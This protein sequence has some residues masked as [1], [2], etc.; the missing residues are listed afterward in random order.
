MTPTLQC[1]MRYAVRITLLALTFGLLNL[2]A[3]KGTASAQN[4]FPTPEG[5]KSERVR[6]AFKGTGTEFN[7]LKVSD[8]HLALYLFEGAQNTDFNR[9]LQRRYDQNLMKYSA[10]AKEWSQT[11]VRF[12]QWL[13][14]AGVDFLDHSLKQGPIQMKIDPMVDITETN[15]RFDFEAL[16]PEIKTDW[17]VDVWMEPTQDVDFLF[18]YAPVIIHE[19]GHFLF[20]SSLNRESMIPKGYR[21]VMFTLGPIDEAFADAVSYLFTSETLVGR[22]YDYTAQKMIEFRRALSTTAEER[23]KVRKG[24]WDYKISGGDDHIQGQAYRDVLIEIAKDYGLKAMFDV[25]LE[26]QR[27][28]TRPTSQIVSLTSSRAEVN[29]E[30]N[31]VVPAAFAR[32]PRLTKAV[33]D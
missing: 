24:K 5:F 18:G 15:A 2:I 1:K 12:N 13:L 10:K 26:I 6:R 20:H 17:W 21:F 22:R 14:S 19:L 29:Q 27:K 4:H 23:E 3:F 32:Y 30:Y 16:E 28:L 25:N 31:E 8:A 9:G 7:W 33:R 11:L